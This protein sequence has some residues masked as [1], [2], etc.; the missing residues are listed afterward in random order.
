MPGYGLGMAITKRLVE[1][2]GGTIVG[3][4]EPGGGARFT[5]QLPAEEPAGVPVGPGESDDGNAA[6]R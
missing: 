6:G 2:H 4:N 1:A 5:I 3:S